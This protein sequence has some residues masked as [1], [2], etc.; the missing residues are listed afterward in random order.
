MFLFY[1]ESAPESITQSVKDAID[2]GYRFFDTT[3]GKNEEEVGLAIFEKMKEGVVNRYALII[4]FL[5]R[6]RIDFKL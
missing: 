5:H 2:L 4:Y 6:H 1:Q 3:P